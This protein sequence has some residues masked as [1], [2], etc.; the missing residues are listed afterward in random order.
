MQWCL[1]PNSPNSFPL[2]S[3]PHHSDSFPEFLPRLLPGSNTCLYN[4][5]GSLNASV[6]L[7]Q[8]FH[9]VQ[10]PFVHHQTPVFACKNPK[11]LPHG[12]YLMFCKREQGGA[13]SKE[14][15]L[16]FISLTCICGLYPFYYL[17]LQVLALICLAFNYEKK[18]K[19]WCIWFVF[20]F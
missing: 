2:S 10:S 13:Y 11:M 15:L 6:K 8:Q 20:L 3:S 14:L 12:I 5:C 17:E 1:Y 18:K 16:L 4:L 19:S 9:P 7:C